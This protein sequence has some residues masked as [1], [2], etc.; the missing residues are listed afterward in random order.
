MQVQVF[1]QSE[2]LNEVEVIEIDAQAGHEVLLRTC[3]GKLGSTPVEELFLFIEDDDDELPL[4]K[5]ECIPEGIRVHLHRLKVIDV[6]VRYAGRDV[7]RA[8][9]PSASVGRI[10]QWSTRE[11]GIAPSDASELMLQVSGT[12]NRPDADVHVGTLVNAP[13]HR[14]TFDLV[15]S[16]RVNG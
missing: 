3:I 1:L 12:D 5:H 4:G 14:I 6:I 10:K 16:P 15:P 8:F 11:L 9:R 2:L 7:R 13:Q